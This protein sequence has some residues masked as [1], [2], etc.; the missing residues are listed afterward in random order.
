MPAP[1]PDSDSAA[2][3][4]ADPVTASISG[5]DKRSSPAAAECGGA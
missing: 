3:A 2:L 4:L 1:S 5:L